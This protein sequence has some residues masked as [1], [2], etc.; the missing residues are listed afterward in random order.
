[1][2]CRR[3]LK[4]NA[5]KFFRTP[6]VTAVSLASLAG[7]YNAP[8][9]ERPFEATIP[10]IWT[11]VSINA[12]LIT[13]C[14]PAIKG[15]LMDW[16][17]GVAVGLHRDL[18]SLEYTTGNTTGGARSSGVKSFGRS[19]PRSHATLRP[20]PEEDAY[21]Y[22]ARGGRGDRDQGADDGDSKKGLTDGIVQTVDYRVDY[23]DGEALRKRSTSSDGRTR[24]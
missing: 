23:E 9:A 10:S 2:C 15:V 19:Q 8:A 13:T 18:S 22:Y 14:L 16:A 24:I 20:R 6:I 17:A 11:S 7:F 21:T 1:M 4:S 3:G 12:S 5:N